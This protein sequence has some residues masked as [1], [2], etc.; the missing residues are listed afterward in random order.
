MNFSTNQVRHFY[1]ANAE[2]D[3]TVGEKGGYRYIEL[4]NGDRSDLIELSKITH[5]EHTLAKELALSNKEITV[6]LKEAEAGVVYPVKVL[7][8]NIFGAGDE[9]SWPIVAAEKFTTAAEFYPAIAKTLNANAKKYGALIFEGTDSGLTITTNLA[10]YNAAW[11]AAHTPVREVKV[12]LLLDTEL[13]DVPKEGFTAV[14][15]E[16]FQ[17][18]K[19]LAELEWFCMGE[20]GDQYRMVGYPNVIKTDYKIDPSKAYDV[21]DIM[22]Y[23]T[24]TKEG[25]QRSEKVITIAAVPAEATK[26]LSALKVTA[27]TVE[28]KPTVD[29]DF[30]G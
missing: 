5:I 18:G 11:D 14:D 25:V 24:D 21:I 9:T 7:L 29:D 2:G 13:W 12:D 6:S 23:Y 22:Y 16:V 20:R 30:L 17:S 10:E 1:V 8:Y 26:L 28:G 3:L 19:K 27:D 15:G 4:A